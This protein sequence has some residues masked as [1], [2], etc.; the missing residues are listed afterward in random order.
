MN[1]CANFLSFQSN[2]SIRTSKKIGWK[3]EAIFTIQAL[4]ATTGTE[5]NIRDKKYQ[6][7]K[8]SNLS[9]SSKTILPILYSKE[10]V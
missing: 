7:V 3:I 9:R 2:E 1:T 10:L 5:Y 6:D 8:N 4:K